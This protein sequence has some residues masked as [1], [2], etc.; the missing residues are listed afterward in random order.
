MEAI[1]EP[2]G[3]AMVMGPAAPGPMVRGMLPMLPM[4]AGPPIVVP[5]GM[6]GM[7]LNDPGGILIIGCMLDWLP[8]ETSILA[9]DL[10]QPGYGA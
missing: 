4:G 8:I 10:V 1:M 5:I 6:A 7:L 3:P 2:G 9:S